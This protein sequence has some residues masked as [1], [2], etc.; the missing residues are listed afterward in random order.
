MTDL[1][2]LLIKNDN[3]LNEGLLLID[4]ALKIDPTDEELL[5]AIYHTKGNGLYK[6]SKNEEALEYLR[7]A[8]YL[9]GEYE[10]DHYIQIQEIKK[11]LAGQNP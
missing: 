2:R 5:A 3:D 11:A 7:K 9:R 10:Y 4:Q 1:A 6:Q 8:L